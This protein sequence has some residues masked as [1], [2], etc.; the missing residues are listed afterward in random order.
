MWSKHLN[1]GP[2][3]AVT[4]PLYLQL[5]IAGGFSLDRSNTNYEI[6]YHHKL[7]LMTYFFRSMQS[8]WGEKEG[9]K[10]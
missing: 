3:N 4:W 7:K 1:T 10:A 2:R 6:I 8:C 5:W 9:G